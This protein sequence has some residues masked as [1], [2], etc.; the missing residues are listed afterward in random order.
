MIGRVPCIAATPSVQPTDGRPLLRR[1]D[2]DGLT[3]PVGAT[4]MVARCQERSNWHTPCIDAALCI[5]SRLSMR[6]VCSK[7]LL[8]RIVLC[9]DKDREQVASL[10]A[11]GDHQGRPYG[12]CETIRVPEAGAIGDHQGCR[13]NGFEQHFA[14]RLVSYFV[15]SIV[16]D[17]E[18]PQMN[19]I[20]NMENK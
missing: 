14:G 12:V 8:Y 11:P 20:E 1:G 16:G 17:Y 18:I 3:D 6:P 5:V 15:L 13:C 7:R 10:L 2:L 9:Y 19:N 4:L